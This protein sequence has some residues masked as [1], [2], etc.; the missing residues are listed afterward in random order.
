MRQEDA[1]IY[2]MRSFIICSA[3]Q[4]LM[5]W[6]DMW[7]HMG[8]AC[9]TDRG[10][11]KYIQHF[12]LKRWRQDSLSPGRRTRGLNDNIKMDRKERGWESVHW[13]HLARGR[14]QWRTVVNTAMKLNHWISYKAGDLLI[15]STTVSFSSRT[16]VNVYSLLYKIAV[17]NFVQIQDNC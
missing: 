10:E 5:L 3:H 1:E 14:A 8:R 17:A 2:S 15:I 6:S 13:I 16:K 12:S 9:N 7:D 11:F 4:T